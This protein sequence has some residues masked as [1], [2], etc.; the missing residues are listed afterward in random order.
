MIYSVYRHVF[1]D[2]GVKMRR[3]L[4]ALALTLSLAAPAVAG[5]FED[6]LEAFD[7][8]SYVNATMSWIPEAVHGNGLAQFNLGVMCLEGKGTHPNPI[9]GLAWVS[10]AVDNLPEGEN[11]AT[12][13]ALRDKLSATL[14]PEEVKQ[15]NELKQ[16]WEKEHKEVQRREAAGLPMETPLEATPLPG[17]VSMPAPIPGKPASE[18]PQIDFSK[19][20]KGATKKEESSAEKK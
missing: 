12:A 14:P 6:G 19:K 4:A 1:P 3:F 20:A 17:Q 2:K 8:G 7:K 10:L 13:V 16:Q 5:D 9:H 15:A 11:R 18:Q